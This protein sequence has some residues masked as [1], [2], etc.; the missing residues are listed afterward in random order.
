MKYIASVLF[1][2]CVTLAVLA[3][4]S[5]HPGIPAVAA[6]PYHESLKDFIRGETDTHDMV[7]QVFQNGV[8]ICTSSTG[9][10]A[11]CVQLLGGTISS[12]QA[13]LPTNTSS[14]TGANQGIGVE[15]V[16]GGV[17]IPIQSD[18][19][20]RILVNCAINCNPPL[21]G[22]ANSIATASGQ[23]VGIDTYNPSTATMEALQS[24]NGG[25]QLADPCAQGWAN[26]FTGFVNATASGNTQLIAGTASKKTYLCSLSVFSNVGAINIYLASATGSSCAGATQVYPTISVATQYAFIAGGSGTGTYFTSNSTS[27]NYLCINLSAGVSS[28]GVGV[29]YNY[30]EQ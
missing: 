20:G 4:Q 11:L 29:Y 21:T 22:G 24:Y 10:A 12:G 25:L 3:F 2:L 6:T 1:G 13:P 7:A 23:S 16:N 28:P 15:G 30:V 26:R 9:Q 19:A 5:G 27:T 8:P 14:P 17:N 18:V